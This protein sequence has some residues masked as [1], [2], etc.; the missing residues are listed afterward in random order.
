MQDMENSQNMGNLQN[1]GIT[2]CMYIKNMRMYKCA[3]VLY[4]H[5]D[6]HVIYPHTQRGGYA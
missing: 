4:I 6:M 3:G 1:M 5:L 2:F